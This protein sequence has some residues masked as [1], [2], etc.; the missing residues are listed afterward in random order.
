MNDDVGGVGG[1]VVGGGW[2]VG[3]R[4][5]TAHAEAAEALRRL[6]V[7]RRGAAKPHR[8]VALAR[9]DCRA[10]SREAELARL[11]AEDRGAHAAG[12][13]EVEP[14][15][16][17]G[18]ALHHSLRRNLHLLAHHLSELDAAS[19]AG[20]DA[21]VALDVL[22]AHLPLARG[23]CREESAHRVD[24][25]RSPRHCHRDR[26]LNPAIHLH[27]ARSTHRHLDVE[28]GGHAHGRDAAARCVARRHDSEVARRVGA[29]PSAHVHLAASRLGRHHAGQV[30]LHVGAHDEAR[31]RARDKERAAR[32]RGQSAR[33][34]AGLRQ[35]GAG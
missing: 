17:E 26:A 29:G 21:E 24:D 14:L 35:Q 18:A 10:A 28:R 6:H 16:V 34:P 15:R 12:G 22:D 4:R 32:L 30:R 33:R 11:G 8:Q 3:G 31:R 7:E 2:L 23:E 13:G 9:V 27:V 1:G 19:A 25:D 20:E 5:V